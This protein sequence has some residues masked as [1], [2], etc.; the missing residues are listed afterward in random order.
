MDASGC[1]LKLRRVGRRRPVAHPPTTPAL[2]FCAIS[3]DVV[4]RAGRA[5]PILLWASA[6]MMSAMTALTP[7]ITQQR[8]ENSLLL[9]VEARIQRRCRLG[10]ELYFRRAFR[11]A[12]RNAVQPIDQ[13]RLLV[14][15]LMGAHLAKAIG[16][17]LRDDAQRR[18]ESRPVLLLIGRE[19]QGR[20]EADEAGV[21]QGGPFGHRWAIA[22]RRRI[23]ILAERGRGERRTGEQGDGGGGEDDFFHERPLSKEVG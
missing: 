15:V 16:A 9:V 20:L 11:Q 19:F 6:P 5:P 17:I 12:V 21:E 4:S 1:R 10:D 7:E 8:G 13:R 2:S 23:V 22:V 3:P 18:F 14:V